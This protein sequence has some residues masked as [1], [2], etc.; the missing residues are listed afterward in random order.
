SM[1]K[2]PKF[3]KGDYN[4]FPRKSIGEAMVLYTTATTATAMVGRVWEQAQIGDGVELM[5]ELPPLPPPPP[6]PMNPPTVSCVAAPATIR[7]G[8]TANIRCT[9]TSPDERPL[10][11]TFSTD[12]GQIVPRGEAAT[13][14]SR[15]ARPGVASIAAVVSD[16]RG[17]SANTVTRV[18]IE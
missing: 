2:Q 8:E 15:N 16:D 14:D 7:V 18:N 4:D 5:D 17:L 9:G 13:L 3:K 1:T 11:Y 10:S 12:I 6:P